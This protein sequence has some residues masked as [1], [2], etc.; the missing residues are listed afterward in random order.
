MRRAAEDGARAVVH[1]D[2]VGD[3]D[4]HH[5][6]GLQRMLGDEAGV[7]ADLL[8]RL[9]RGLRRAGAI[10]FRDEGRDPG[11]LRGKLVDQRV[12]RRERDEGG[13]EERVGARREDLELPVAARDPPLDIGALRLADP[14]LLHQPDLLGPAREPVE[15]GAQVVG[16]GGDPEEPLRELALL[17][18][19][20]GA[21]ALAVDHLLVGE[22]GLVD[23]IPVDEGLLAMDEA[24][25]H[26]VQE[27]LLLVLVVAGVA[28]RDLALPVEA[29]A[30]ALQ[31]A[32]HRRDVVVGPFRGVDAVLAR[33][34]LRRQAKG[35]PAHRVH[36]LEAARALV[37]GDHVAQRV[38]A[39]MAHVDAP[40]RVGEHLEHVVLGLRAAAVR[41]GEAIRRLPGG[42]PLRL[43]FLH[44]VARHRRFRAVWTGASFRP[45]PRPWQSARAGV[46]PPRR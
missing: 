6:P 16:R 41:R 24:G 23:G 35:V 4:R 19:R 26:E 9:D 37:A 10:A 21:P 18:R 14:V 45:K 42:L 22:H 40:R 38:V 5:A 31:L 32:A 36:D 1:E 28:G 30:H 20:A 15:R 8:G 3:P 17:H 13:A 39:H 34:V 44:V 2:E 7:V 29:E 33:G 43:G 11:I 27:Q 46:R 12:M 25:L